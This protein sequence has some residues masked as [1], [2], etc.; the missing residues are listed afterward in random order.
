MEGKHGMEE[1]DG[2]EEGGRKDVGEEEEAEK[3]EE[4]WR[5]GIAKSLETETN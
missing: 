3:K 1:E 2:V 4:V 5:G